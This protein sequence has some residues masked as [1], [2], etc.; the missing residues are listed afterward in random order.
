MRF[1][2]HSS[3]A[4]TVVVYSTALSKEWSEEYDS[5]YLFTKY[6]FK[7]Y[8]DYS[9]PSLCAD[10]RACVSVAKHHETNHPRRPPLRRG[11]TLAA[12]ALVASYLQL[13]YLSLHCLLHLAPH[14]GFILGSADMHLQKVG[15]VAIA[16]L[17]RVAEDCHG[18]IIDVG[19][20]RSRHALRSQQCNALTILL[21]HVVR[22][23][24]RTCART[25]QTVETVACR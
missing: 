8:G 15:F 22:V 17:I 13:S 9:L 24:N 23:C 21:L 19:P 18:A 4:P 20:G 3:P 12:A 6:R 16:G 7:C 25:R 5:L 14:H 11:R 10:L 2:D 1:P